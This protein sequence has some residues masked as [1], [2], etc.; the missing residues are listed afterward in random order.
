MIVKVNRLPVLTHALIKC[1]RSLCAK[2]NEVG[3]SG[4]NQGFDLVNP[5]LCMDLDALEGRLDGPF[6][7]PDYRSRTTRQDVAMPVAISPQHKVQE[8][9]QQEWLMRLD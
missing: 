4:S 9:V 3:R 2:G 5:R 8:R 7:G 6:S 1:S